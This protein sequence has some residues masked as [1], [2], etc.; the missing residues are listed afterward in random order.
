VG[1]N[2]RIVALKVSPKFAMIAGLVFYEIKPLQLAEQAE[3]SCEQ[4]T[5]SDLMPIKRAG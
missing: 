3:N 2:Q 4:L 1:L 5:E